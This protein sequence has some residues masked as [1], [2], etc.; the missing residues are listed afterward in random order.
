MTPKV[1]RSD[2]LQKLSKTNI[3]SKPTHYH[4]STQN[5]KIMLKIKIYNNQTNI[6]IEF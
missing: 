2:S 4:H 6:N 3:F 1:I 5:L